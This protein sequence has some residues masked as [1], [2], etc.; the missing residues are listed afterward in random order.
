MYLLDTDTVSHALRGNLLDERLEAMDPA[1]WCISAVTRAELRYGVARRLG[2]TRL[3]ELVDAF[4]V[5]A[6]CEPWDARAADRHGALRAALRGMEGGTIG[7]YDEMI[8][9][10]ALALGAVLVTGNVRHF[11]RVPGLVVEDWIRR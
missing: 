5:V 1:E 4:L 8:A 6:R 10:H 11:R 3:A 9:A 2:A 7:A